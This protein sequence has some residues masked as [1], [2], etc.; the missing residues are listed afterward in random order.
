MGLERGLDLFRVDLLAAGVD[1][2]RATAE[3]RHRAVVFETGEVARARSTGVPVDLDERGRRLHGILVVA[4][5]DVAA[6]GHPADLAGL[7]RLVVVIDHDRVPGPSFTLIRPPSF[8]VALLL[9]R[10]ACR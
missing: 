1:A 4:D 3:Q 6:A 10:A 5:R 9:D 8:V 7:H 2:L